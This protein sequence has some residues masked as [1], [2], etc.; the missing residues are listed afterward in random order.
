MP[1]RTPTGI[2]ASEAMPTMIAVPAM[3]LATPPPGIPVGRCEFRKNS[4]WDTAGRPLEA[5]NQST[6][7]R[8]MR[9]STVNAYITPCAKVLPN[10]RM[11]MCLIGFSYQRSRPRRLDQQEG[12]DVDRQGDQ[13]ED[14]PDLDQRA[15]I[16]VTGRLCELVGDDC[17]QGVARRKHRMGDLGPVADHHRHGN[18][19][20][21]R[22]AEREHGGAE[23]AG[24][25]RRQDHLPG[26][27]PPCGTD[28]RGETGYTSGGDAVTYRLVD[29]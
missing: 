29:H 26:R 22:A 1:L 18:R 28:G 24:A 27:L 20:R 21:Q 23:D 8:G 16:D 12:Q 14:Q 2:A 4:R 13:D 6:S 17:R 25:R 15:L 10:R 11:T 5:V 3:A 9:A 7:P 19:L